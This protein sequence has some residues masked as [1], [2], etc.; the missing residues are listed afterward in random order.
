MFVLRNV[1]LPFYMSTKIRLCYVRI[2]ACSLAAMS[3]AAAI[4]YSIDFD[5]AQLLKIVSHGSCV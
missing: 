5:R 3:L 4:A 1:V 2:A